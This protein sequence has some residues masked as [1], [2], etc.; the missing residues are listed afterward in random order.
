MNNLRKSV[1]IAAS[2]GLILVSNACSKPV[3][4]TT[5]SGATTVNISNN[6]FQPGTMTARVGTTVNF[7]NMMGQV[8]LVGKSGFMMG[9]FSG[10][11]MQTG[12]GFQYTFN[13][14][15]TYV[16]GVSGQNFQCTIKVVS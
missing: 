8:T 9:S 5:V 6:A 4:S 13:T 3:A 15:G 2:I 7:Y 14:P 16:V 11:M 10:M 1:L 12:T